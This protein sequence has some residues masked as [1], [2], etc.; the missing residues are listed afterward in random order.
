MTGGNRIAETTA[1]LRVIGWMASVTLTPEPADSFGAAA[2]RTGGT[3]Q[4]K[5]R[6]RILVG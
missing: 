6:A 2:S 1:G 4:P 5:P 3:R